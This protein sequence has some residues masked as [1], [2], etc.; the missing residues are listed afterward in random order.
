MKKDKESRLWVLGTSSKDENCNFEELDKF[1]LFSQSSIKNLDSSSISIESFY[2]RVNFNDDIDSFN[3]GLKT[4]LLSCDQILQANKINGSFYDSGFWLVHRLTDLFFLHS[5]CDQIDNQFTNI[6]LIVPKDF[7]KLFIRDCSLEDLSFNNLGAGLEHSLQFLHYGLPNSEIIYS[8]TR[9]KKWIS[10]LRKLQFLKRSPEILHR[11]INNF[12]STLKVFFL[13]PATKKKILIAQTGYDADFLTRSYSKKTFKTISLKIDKDNLLKD[14]MSSNTIENLEIEIN[15]F[16]LKF[17]PRFS[18]PLNDFFNSFIKKIS[19]YSN[20]IDEHLKNKL[21]SNKVDAL[22]FSSG[23]TS[24]VERKT[25]LQANKLN[26]SVIFMRHQGIEINFFPPSFLDDFCENDLIIHRTQFLLND[27]EIESYPIQDRINY[28]KA[29]FIEFSKLL[30][31]KKEKKGILYSAGP[32]E[33]FTFKNPRAI[34]TNFERF[35]FVSKLIS[36]INKFNLQLDIKVHPAEWKSSAIFFRNLVNKFTRKNKPKILLDGSI[37]RIMM[38]YELIILDI[39]STRVLNFALYHNLQVIL[40]VPNDYFLN[41]IPFEDLEKRIHI[42]RDNIE[43]ERALQ[44][45]Y[46]GKLEFK[47]NPMFDEKY[48]RDLSH[49]ELIAEAYREIVN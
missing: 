25:C 26:I 3:H 12:L 14:E 11:K 1:L 23:A 21:L 47:S 24:L 6:K 35:N 27:Y 8:K 18:L 46:D 15:K 22:A 7:E 32:P 10:F 16:L 28:K 2:S 38:N 36:S 43:L 44:K 20:S 17:L 29:G 34:I 48:L 45:F 19:I 9:D 40:Y 13:K 49:E 33:H 31:S 4:L 41:E 30:P 37:E 42:V 5:L 39:I